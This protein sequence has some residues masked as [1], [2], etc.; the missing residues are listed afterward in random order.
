[1]SLEYEPSSE[2][3]NRF[4]NSLLSCTFNPHLQ[5]P[6][7]VSIDLCHD[8]QRTGVVAYRLYIVYRQV[9]QVP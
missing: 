3:L 2:P 8:T 7:S 9:C 1:M 5:I 6:A 4:L